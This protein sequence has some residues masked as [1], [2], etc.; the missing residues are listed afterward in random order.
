MATTS[1]DMSE[2]RSLGHHLATA[3]ARIAP[4]LDALVEVHARRIAAQARVNAPKDRPWLGTEQGIVV[5]RRR[6]MSR[7]IESPLDDTRP[8]RPQSVGYRVEYGTSTQ[9]PRPFLG[10]A[11]ATGRDAYNADALRLLIA[12]SL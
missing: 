8:G 9:P 3:G 6:R 1:M 10:P 5:H 2:V 12:N 11:V 4:Q 7:T